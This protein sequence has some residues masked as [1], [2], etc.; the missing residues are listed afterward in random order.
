MSSGVRGEEI[1]GIRYRAAK[2]IHPAA[3]M[4]P[5]GTRGTTLIYTINR[6]APPDL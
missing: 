4:A 6:L 1:K 3:V 2:C 5:G